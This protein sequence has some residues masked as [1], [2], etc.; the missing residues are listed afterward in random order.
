M[1]KNI[2]LFVKYYSLGIILTYFIL[3]SCFAKYHA[4]D[5]NIIKKQIIEIGGE[6]FKLKPFLI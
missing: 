1:I 4:L 3:N 2:L 6:K 5:S